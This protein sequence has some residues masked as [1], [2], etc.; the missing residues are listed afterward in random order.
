MVVVPKCTFD[1]VNDR[2]Q[3]CTMG[4]VARR[5]RSG[6]RNAWPRGR[7]AVCTCE[8]D[9]SL[10]IVC[11]CNYFWPLQPFSITVFSPLATRTNPDRNVLQNGSLPRF[12][13]SLTMSLSDMPP[14][15]F[16]PEQLAWLQATLPP[17]PM[18][19]PT[20][21]GASALAGTDPSLSAS[22][23]PSPGEY[24]GGVAVPVCSPRRVGVKC[25]V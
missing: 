4:R 5:M 8:R 10:P 6:M 13:I 21:L 20:G 14:E 19:V 22:S 1:V 24:A 16:K 9:E 23:A 11:N 2:R 7:A 15:P 3:T 25:V 17:P 12:P 18:A